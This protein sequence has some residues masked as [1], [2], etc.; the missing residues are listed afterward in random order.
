MQQNQKSRVIT[1]RSDCRPAFCC[2]SPAG[3]IR[4]F[5]H[6]HRFTTKFDPSVPSALFFT[7]AFRRVLARPPALSAPAGNPTH[8]PPLGQLPFS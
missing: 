7:G 6:H 5:T 3:S 4:P 1:A 8:P 2:F